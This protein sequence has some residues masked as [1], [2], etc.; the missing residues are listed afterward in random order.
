MDATRVMNTLRNDCHGKQF[1]QLSI[2]PE[3][4]YSNQSSTTGVCGNKAYF[5]V[6]MPCQFPESEFTSRLTA[7]LIISCIAVFLYLISIFWMD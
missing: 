1:C 6:Q 3:S 2:A 7:G 5:F 4:L